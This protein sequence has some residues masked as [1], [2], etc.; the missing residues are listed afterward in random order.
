MGDWKQEKPAWCPHPDCQFKVRGQDSICIGMLPSPR[1]HDG[2]DNTHRLCQRGTPDDGAWLHTI[3][4]NRG[5]AWNFVR[6]LKMG[7]GIK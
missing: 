6:I 3:E 1:K 2:V 4:L 5:D 7:F